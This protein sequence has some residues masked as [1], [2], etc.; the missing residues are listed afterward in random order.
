MTSCAHL[1][2]SRH[3]LRLPCCSWIAVR[4][5]LDLNCSHLPLTQNGRS[6]SSRA[7]QAG[8]CNASRYSQAPLQ[9]PRQFQADSQHATTT[10]L[11]RDSRAVRSISRRWRKREELGGRPREAGGLQGGGQGQSGVYRIDGM[12]RARLTRRRKQGEG[13]RRAGQKLGRRFGRGLSCSRRML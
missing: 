11:H 6:W 7:K 10:P 1:A 2:E 5:R 3:R 9:R 8:P 13:G 4:G 12:Q